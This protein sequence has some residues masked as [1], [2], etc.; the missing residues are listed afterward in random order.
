MDI[1]FERV[2]AQNES[3]GAACL[4][5]SVA[6]YCKELDD[7]RGMPIAQAFIVLPLVFNKDSATTIEG[8]TMTEGSFFR[9]LT[10]N[11]AL[12][13]GVQR[14]V[15]SM[16]QLTLDSLNLGLSSELIRLDPEALELFPGRK[17]LPGD[18]PVSQ[19]SSNVR[20]ALG[21]A[22]RVGYWLATTPIGVL[23]NL[24]KVNF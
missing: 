21:A 15:T 8:K 22:R 7:G 18:K 10:E 19:L 14:R 1:D 13:G 24:L 16:V 3:F 9:A 4:W 11:R 12:A 20:V 2:I 5:E 17:S 23:C 6:R